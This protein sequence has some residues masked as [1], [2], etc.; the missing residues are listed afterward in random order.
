MGNDLR[1]VSPVPP[2]LQCFS[3]LFFIFLCAWSSCVLFRI[4]QSFWGGRQINWDVCECTRREYSIQKWAS[5][6]EPSPRPQT[7]NTIRIK[8]L[9]A[10]KKAKG[11]ELLIRD[12]LTSNTKQSCKSATPV[13]CTLESRRHHHPCRTLLVVFLWTTCPCWKMRT[14]QRRLAFLLLSLLFLLTLQTTNSLPVSTTTRPMTVEANINLGF[15]LD[16]VIRNVRMRM[17]D[18]VDVYIRV[19]EFQSRNRR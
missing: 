11:R 10:A 5:C 14:F 7:I 19:E 18:V 4:L 12:S 16:D 13:P 2:L 1:I 15:R 3:H 17:R 8:W 9:L 6:K